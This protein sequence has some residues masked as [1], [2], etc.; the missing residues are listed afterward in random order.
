MAKFVCAVSLYISFILLLGKCHASND[1]RK[2]YIVYMG[3]I[4]NDNLYLPTSH[5][6]SLLQEVTGNSDD[7]YLIR[8]YKRSFNGFAAKLTD[9]EAQKLSSMESVVSVFPSKTLHLQ[10]TRSWDF[11]GFNDNTIKSKSSAGSEVIIGV[12]DTG[13]WP[14][15]P[16]FSDKGFGPV[17]KKW[18]GVCKG[19]A[20]FTCNN[21]VIG[22]RVYGDIKS[23][24]DTIGHG[25]HTASTA[26]GNKVND[27]SFFG[28]AKGIARGGSPSARIAI[29]KVCGSRTCSTLDIVAGFDDAI[30]D[31]VD[32]VTISIGGENANPFEQDG[33]AIGAYHAFAKG[34]VVTHSAGNAGPDRGSTG[35]V[36]PWLLSVAASTTDRLFIDK[37][38]LGNG[39]TLSGLSINTFSLNGTKYPLAYGEDVARNCPLEYVQSCDLGCLDPK[40]VKGKIVLCDSYRGISDPSLKNAAGVIYPD[41]R[42]NISSVQP[43]PAMGLGSEKYNAIKSYLSSD[44]NAKA[45]ILKSETIKD[46]SAPVVAQFSS[47]GPNTIA[48]DILKPD[49]SAPGVDI[50][51]AFSPL[52]SPSRGSENVDSRRV[53]YSILS[54]TSMSC[55]HV[56]GVAAYIKSLHPDWSPSAIK[57]AIMT[58][59]R[60]MSPITNPDAEFAYGSGHI[61]PVRVSNPGLVYDSSAQDIINM[62]CGLG[63][64]DDQIKTITGNAS[65]CL[66]KTAPKDLNYPSLAAVVKPS[67]VFTVKFH[68]RVTNVGKSNSTYEAKVVSNTKS[69]LKI[70]VTPSTLSFKSLN[71]IKSFK[72]YVN[73][74][75]SDKEVAS[76]AIQWSDGVHLV[77]S[78]LVVYTSNSS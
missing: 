36:A 46:S 6:A 5:H 21:K 70:T 61:D 54:G 55:P 40:K 22:A 63:F 67:E 15:S 64:N 65:K 24:R 52:V 59:A 47:R 34:I 23:A 66:I 48:G 44:K 53:G 16:S 9:I 18:K 26:A 17:P 71:E 73:G 1:E 32:I 78:L 10:T 74:Q 58:T 57:S 14:E 60:P 50:L 11:M 68:R 7:N 4:P 31:G 12:F 27:I 76:A 75:I 77:R 3:A 69:K 72:V 41:D 29:Y 13:L 25:S 28:L 56:A 20:N 35:S 43:L 38:V 8:S 39:K 51:A 42:V 49:I 62:F 19:G 33:L 2:D 30:A 37:V 45:E